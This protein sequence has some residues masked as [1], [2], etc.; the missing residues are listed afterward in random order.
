MKIRSKLTKQKQ[1]KPKQNINN[2][3]KQTKNVILNYMAGMVNLYERY[4][5]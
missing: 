5:R 2:N 3:K 1:N 4:F